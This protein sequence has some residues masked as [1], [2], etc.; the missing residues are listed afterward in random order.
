[1][2]AAQ[3]TST[4]PG[5]GRGARVQAVDQ[6]LHR[7]FGRAVAGVAFPVAADD[8]GARGGGARGRERAAQGEAGG[9][10]SVQHQR[11]GGIRCVRRASHRSVFMFST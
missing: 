2:G 6:R 5:G 1:M 8:G 7:P 3:N 10:D 11:R 9:G 4:D